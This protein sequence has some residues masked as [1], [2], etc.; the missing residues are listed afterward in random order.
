MERICEVCER[1]H[2]HH[3]IRDVEIARGGLKAVAKDISGFFCDNCDEFEFDDATDSAERYAAAGDE[4]VLRARKILGDKLR[5]ARI[6]LNLTQ[7]QA[8]MITGGGHNAFSRYETGNAQPMQ[9]VINL[10]SLLEKHPELLKEL[11]RSSLAA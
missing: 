6:K 8:S 1:G 10:F 11:D 9:A 3:A 2:L 4:L 5:E 7:A